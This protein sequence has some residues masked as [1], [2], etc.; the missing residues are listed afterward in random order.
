MTKSKIENQKFGRGMA[1]RN[2]KGPRRS[3]ILAA[4]VAALVGFGIVALVLRSQRTEAPPA[5][6]AAETATPPAGGGEEQAARTPAAAE[7]PARAAATPSTRSPTADED[8]TI[9][10]IFGI[11]EPEPATPIPER[12]Q[13]WLTTFAS[14]TI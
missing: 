12:P 1:E 4:I 9:F 7:Q 3:T 2:V 6:E 14:V 10:S 13:D 5:R 8:N 11:N